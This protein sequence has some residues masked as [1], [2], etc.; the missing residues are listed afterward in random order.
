MIE[1]YLDRPPHL[2]QDPEREAFSNVGG[3]CP[4]C[5]K[6]RGPI[7]FGRDYWFVCDEHEFLWCIGI[8]ITDAWK[9]ITDE[10]RDVAVAE[11]SDYRLWPEEP[12]APAE[13]D[14]HTRLE[15][16]RP[17]V[18]EWTHPPRP[19]A[20]NRTLQELSSQLKTA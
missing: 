15:A 19:H 12:I 18:R 17:G 7:H 4:E 10:V 6:R 8:G 9:S 14:A 5:G 20:D 13:R 1:T 2:N 16:L 3:G 11:T